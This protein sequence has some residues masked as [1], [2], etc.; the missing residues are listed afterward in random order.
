M[1]KVLAVLL[2][3][4]F[5]MTAVLTGCGGKETT[6][7]GSTSSNGS[8]SSSNSSQSTQAQEPG[9]P[10]TWI[11]DRH[12]VVRTFD[13]DVGLA[14]PDDQINN[15]VAQKIKELTGITME[16]QYTPADSSKQA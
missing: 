2:V 16:V 4:T 5:T 3:L 10:D 9:K 15:E 12:I 8:K 6:D 1:K 14:L 7:T 11:A 13:P